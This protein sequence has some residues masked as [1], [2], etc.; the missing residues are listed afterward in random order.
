MS[1]AMGLDKSFKRRIFTARTL[2]SDMGFLVS[3]A[4][5][6][7]K[8]T[9]DERISKA[10][11]EKIMTVTTAVNGCVYCAWFHARQAVESGIS[12]EEVR[13]MLN[14]QFQADATEFEM[15]ALLYAQ[16][17]AET[18]RHPDPAM[19]DRLVDFYGEETAA[20]IMLFI[21]MIFFGNL[22]G[23][24]WDATLSRFRGAPAENSNLA[25]DLVFFLLNFPVMCPATIRVNRDQIEMAA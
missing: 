20:H 1:S 4:P 22:Y 18:N 24:T 2:M 8:A 5:E 11:V 9:R 14:L 16:H 3:N 15:P 19:T 25:F 6:I 21:R 13:N 10:F 23:N 17:Y 12:E 7:V